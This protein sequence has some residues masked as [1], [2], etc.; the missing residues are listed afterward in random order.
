MPR[1]NP[2][3]TIKPPQHPATWC[4]DHATE[5]FIRRDSS[6]MHDAKCIGNLV[7]AALNDRPDVPVVVV[8]VERIGGEKQ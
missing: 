6:L 8:V 3:C 2:S 5:V 7:L 4:S 1:G